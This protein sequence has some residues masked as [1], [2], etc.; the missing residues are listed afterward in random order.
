MGPS[1]ANTMFEGI[2][3]MRH[4]GWQPLPVLEMTCEQVRCP[5]ETAPRDATFLVSSPSIPPELFW[6][7]QRSRFP[8]WCM[9]L[10]CLRQSISTIPSASQN[11][12]AITLQ[13]T[14]QRETFWEVEKKHMFPGHT[15]HFTFRIEVM[16]PGITTKNWHVNFLLTSNRV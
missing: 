7:D 15:L 10:S 6:S 1:P 2:A 4:F 9:V 16:N 14:Q 5:G 11:T 3:R 13:P 12:V 8:W